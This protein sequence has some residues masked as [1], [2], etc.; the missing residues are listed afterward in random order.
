[1]YWIPSL[2]TQAA[3]IPT[4]RMLHQVHKSTSKA[5]PST[6]NTIP[7]LLWIPRVNLFWAWTWIDGILQPVQTSLL[8]CHYTQLLVPPHL[9]SSGPACRTGSPTLHLASLHCATSPCQ[10]TQSKG[11]RIIRIDHFSVGHKVITLDSPMNLKISI[12]QQHMHEFVSYI[13]WAC[14]QGELSSSWL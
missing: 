14:I 9:L 8:Q 7:W 6:T 1:M 11:R 3:L 10:A 13:C 4:I 2:K 12:L 5:C